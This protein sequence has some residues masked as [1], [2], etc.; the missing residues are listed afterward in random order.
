MLA[1]LKSRGTA[2]AAIR[3]SVLTGWDH[4]AGQQVAE[5][6]ENRS[7]SRAYHAWLCRKSDV[8]NRQSRRQPDTKQVAKAILL[9][10]L[11]QDSKIDETGS[12][13]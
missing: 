12:F 10:L 2:K 7:R 11:I 8:A 1:Q 5:R 6:K 13:S 4:N 9:N 3:M